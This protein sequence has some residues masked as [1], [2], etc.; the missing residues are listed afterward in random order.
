[1]FT[2]AMELWA[3]PSLSHTM[4]TQMNHASMTNAMSTLRMNA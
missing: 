2:L 1:M 3:P 4:R